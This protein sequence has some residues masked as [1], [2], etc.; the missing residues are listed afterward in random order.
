M[1]VTNCATGKFHSS[2]ILCRSR[3]KPAN[4]IHKLCLLVSILKIFYSLIVSGPFFFVYLSINMLLL[5]LYNYMK[6]MLYYNYYYI[7]YTICN[8]LHSIT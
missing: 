6:I 1:I 8:E 5:Y 7:I 2:E 3:H 4:T